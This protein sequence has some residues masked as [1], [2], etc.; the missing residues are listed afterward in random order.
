[1]GLLREIFRVS[2]GQREGWDLIVLRRWYDCYWVKKMGT[3]KKG[4]VERGVTIGLHW[5]RK[6]SKVGGVIC[7]RGIH[8]GE[9][10]GGLS[11][12]RRKGAVK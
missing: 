6:E 3:T 7:G 5:D 12:R 2:R 8:L 4:G 1:M 9:T 10:V 11:P